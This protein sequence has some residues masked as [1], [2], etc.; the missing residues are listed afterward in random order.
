MRNLVKVWKATQ[1]RCAMA[2]IAVSMLGLSSIPARGGTILSISPTSI[3]GSVGTGLPG[4]EFEVLLTNTGPSA[5]TIG[6]FGFSVT[7]DSSAI[8]LTDALITTVDP[9]IFAGSSLFAVGN[10]IAT[11]TGTTLAASDVTSLAAGVTLGA[12][13]SD[14]LG[15]VTFDVAPSIVTGTYNVTILPYPGTSLADANGNNVPID[16]IT[17]GTITINAAT[18]PEPTT[19]A[20]G[21]EAL[22]AAAGF[23]AWRARS[24]NRA[25]P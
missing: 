18:I 25:R 17:N 21:V 13:A 4:N 11:S 6:S 23:A 14:A 3:N 24:R 20:M 7:T 16:T 12:G 5:V 1:S 15:L 9:Y 8:D 2:A 19:L 10:S 22:I